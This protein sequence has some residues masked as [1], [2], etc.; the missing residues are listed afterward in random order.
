MQCIYNKVN[1]IINKNVLNIIYTKT[2]Y[3]LV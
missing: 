2:I 3:I 1:N